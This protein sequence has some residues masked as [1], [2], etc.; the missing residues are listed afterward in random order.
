MRKRIAILMAVA[1]LA[2]G[3]GSAVQAGPTEPPAARQRALLYLLKQDCGS[4]HGLTLKGG[5]G[6][7]LRPEALHDKSDDLLLDTI[8]HGRPGTPMPPWAF[9]LTA[10]EARWLVQRLRTGDVDG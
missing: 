8:L 1:A 7:A 3:V 4:C 10:E 6:P 9:S 2:V 5:L